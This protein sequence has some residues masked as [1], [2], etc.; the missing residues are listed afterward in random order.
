MCK[1]CI[2]HHGHA[3]R[4]DLPG[5]LVALKCCGSGSQGQKCSRSSVSA[6]SNAVLKRI[7]PDHEP[8]RMRMREHIIH[9]EHSVG[10]GD[11]STSLVRSM[12]GTGGCLLNAGY[13]HRLSQC[14]YREECGSHP[15]AISSS[16]TMAP[17][18]LE[19]LI[20]CEICEQGSLADLRRA[21]PATPH[22]LPSLSASSV[23]SLSLAR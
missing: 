12:V 6:L 7:Q 17:R 2:H 16:F 3:S 1:Q 4:R 10:R 14:L 20:Q 22:P 19:M 18:E 15:S 5:L 23:A 13:R 8:R 9:A 11:M 21:F